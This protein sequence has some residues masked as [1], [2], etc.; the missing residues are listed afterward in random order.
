MGLDGV[1]HRA[2]GHLKDLRH[3]RH[4]GLVLILPSPFS[5]PWRWD[6]DPKSNMELDVRLPSPTNKHD[7]PSWQR[8]THLGLVSGCRVRSP[9]ITGKSEATLWREGD[10]APLQKRRRHCLP[11]QKLNERERLWSADAKQLQ[12]QRA[13]LVV[14]CFL[15]AKLGT[16]NICAFGTLNKGELT[17]SD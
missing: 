5:V 8:H 4:A 6:S 12:E 3:L 11:R 13:S 9:Q 2:G 14:C 1:A 17:M 10:Y 7:P 15:F 16:F